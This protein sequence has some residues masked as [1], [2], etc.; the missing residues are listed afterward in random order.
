M[1][2]TTPAREHAAAE[3][4][5][6]LAG[7]RQFPPEENITDGACARCAFPVRAHH[8]LVALGSN[9][10][11]TIAAL[12]HRG[13]A[14]EVQA[15]QEGGSR[16]VFRECDPRI[17]AEQIGMRNILA[18]SGGRIEVRD[19]GITLPVSNGYRVTVDLAGNDTYTV[20]RMF[21]RAGRTWIKGE[22]AD[23]YC[24]Q[25]GEVAYQASCFRNV[26]F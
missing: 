25:V 14:A 26:E 5:A 8:G 23:V 12:L 22:R 15:A 21:T 2:T 19:T 4:A 11:G 17:L 3:L 18:I 1:T 13:C 7:F 20:R 9:E 24:E 6:V 16:P 10:R